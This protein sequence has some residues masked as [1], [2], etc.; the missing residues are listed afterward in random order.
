MYDV[1]YICVCERKKARE[2]AKAGGRRGENERILLYVVFFFLRLFLFQ[3]ER[4]NTEGE[5]VGEADSS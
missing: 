2:S 3:R 5:A 1:Y 4:E